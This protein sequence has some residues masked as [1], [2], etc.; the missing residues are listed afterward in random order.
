MKKILFVAALLSA[1]LFFACSKSDM[2]NPVPGP[3]PDPVE[4]TYDTLLVL[5]TNDIHAHIANMA[6]EAAYIQTMKRSY[7]NLL[8]VDAGDIFS[9]DPVV[10]QHEERGYPIVDLMN[11]LGYQAMSLGNHDF[12][13]GQEVLKKRVQ[14]A[15]FPILCA[16][17]DFSRTVLKDLIAPFDTMRI[18]GL[19]VA[20]LGL[21]Q[22][23]SSGIP[24]T[25]PGNVK[26]ITFN[27]A[28]TPAFMSQWAFLRSWSDVFVV[29]SHLGDS[30]DTQIVPLFLS[31]PDLV[32]GG[33]SHTT[34]NTG[35][36]VDNVL[37]TQ[38]GAS[39]K[40]IGRTV[41]LLKNKKVVTKTNKLIA[42]SGL[43]AVDP[44]IN[45]LVQ[46]YQ[47]NSPMNRVIGRATAAFTNKEAVANLMTDAMTDQL[48]CDIALTNSGGVRLTNLAAGDITMSKMYE[49]DP[50]NNDVYVFEMTLDQLRTFLKH[51]CRYGSIDYY[52]SGARYTYNTSSKVLVLTDYSGTPLPD[53]KTYRVAM[54][55]Y[56]VET[57]TYLPAVLP[58]LEGE[59]L[60]VGTSATLVEYVINQQTVAPQAS[61]TAIQ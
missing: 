4:T 59:N 13:Y 55:S 6:K 58:D 32:V 31:K 43:T 52:I 60:F 16:N 41:I 30:Y 34:I 27:N 33:H 20:I 50:F 37:I 22:R 8:L 9:G 1:T 12:D 48:D 54:N 25:L 36:T 47:N 2:P 14:Q 23:G 17:A 51:G 45:S 39:L 61:R 42:T 35:R 53:T 44:V 26:D 29:L 7:S 46:S 11:R 3:D 28:I 18:G 5:S 24:S 49:A 38:T 40:S 56:M 19:K 57:S 10:D 15:A 21:I